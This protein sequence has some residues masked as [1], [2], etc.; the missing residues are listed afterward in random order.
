MST[1]DFPIPGYYRWQYHFIV[2][3]QS[4][5]SPLL[6]K[7]AYALSWLGLEW[8]YVVVLPVIFW[9]IHRRIGLRIAYVFLLSMY[10][11][12]WV[13][14]AVHI[15]RPVG[16]PGIVSKYL[17]SAP[18]FSMPS[19]HA[20]G[21]LTFW[22]MIASWVRRA[23]LWVLVLV[24]VGLIGVSRVYLGLHWPMDILVGWGLGFVFG[25]F[26]WWFGRWWHYREL[27]FRFRY[28]VAAA[29]PLALLGLHNDEVSLQYASLLLGIGVGAVLEEQ[30]FC[31]N[32][33]P[34]IWK[35]ICT[36]VIGVAGMLLLYRI[37]PWPQGDVWIV[38]RDILI[39][40]WGTLGA[41]YAFS[42][43]GL[44]RKAA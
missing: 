22:V 21:P 5:H 4:F 3:M 1:L 23:W 37:I 14:A 16:V 32:L 6:D 17:S 39:G 42:L 10:T 44:Y 2:W 19:G 15:A 41:P 34:A 31:L 13:K 18:G 20:Q 7:I 30:R 24:I 29:V 28:F 26:G 8:F 38:I 33:D 43:C 35:R 9:S 11:N 40:L 36:A 12:A 25:F 27:G